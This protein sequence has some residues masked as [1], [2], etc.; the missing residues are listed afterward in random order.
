MNLLRKLAA[1]FAILAGLVAG[2]VALLTVASIVGRT[3]FARPIPGDVELTQFGVALAISLCLP[4][5]QLHGANILVDFFTQHVRP[6]TR[7]RLDAVGA[8][9]VA[10]FCGLL[11]WRAAAGAFS[12]AEAGETTMILDVPMWISYAVLS[13]GLAL[14]ALIALLQSV[15]LWRGRLAQAGDAALPGMLK[16]GGQ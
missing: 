3:F 6:R 7:Q 13:P 2:A 8:L 12:V 5:C 15:A 4:W 1:W 10:V 14:A 9:L 16:E 11:S